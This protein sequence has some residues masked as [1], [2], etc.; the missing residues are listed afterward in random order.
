MRQVVDEFLG[1][2]IREIFLILLLAHVHEGQHGD[3]FFRDR[4]RRPYDRPSLR[5]GIRVAMRCEEAVDRFKI[6]GWPTV[7]FLDHQGNEIKG[8]RIVGVVFQGEEFIKYLNQLG[9]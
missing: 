8:S 2:A 1:Q 5:Q 7:L 9:P 3:G 6:I 4:R